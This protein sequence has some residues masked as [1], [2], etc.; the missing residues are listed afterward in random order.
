MEHDKII[1]KYK[2]I[3]Y[4]MILFYIGS[5]I[6]YLF[7]LNMVSPFFTT[8]EKQIEQKKEEDK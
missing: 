3:N 5:Y 7:F 1:D 8:K 2:P 4:N 6:L